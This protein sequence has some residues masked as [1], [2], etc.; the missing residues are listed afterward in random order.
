[1]PGENSRKR[2]RQWW[3]RTLEQQEDIDLAIILLPVISFLRSLRVVRAMRIARLAKIQQL[4]KMGRLYRLRGLMMRALR[5]LMILQLINRVFRVGPERQLP[6]FRLL[7]EEK[8]AEVHTLSRQIELLERRMQQ[9]KPAGHGGLKS[10]ASVEQRRIG[11][12]HCEE[13]GIPFDL[14]NGSK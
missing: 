2:P 6:K 13:V 1:M 9:Q 7:L 12:T 8:Q 10:A 5:A 3:Y 14:T 4:S 11:I